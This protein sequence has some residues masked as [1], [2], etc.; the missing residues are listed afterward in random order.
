MSLIE[1]LKEGSTVNILEIKSDNSVENV[2][3]ILKIPDLIFVNKFFEESESKG[4]LP[5]KLV[6]IEKK[7]V[8]FFFLKKKNF[9]FTY[10]NQSI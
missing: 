5:Y 1:I 8:F 6:K 3:G 4:N 10:S 9:I 7:I 2:D